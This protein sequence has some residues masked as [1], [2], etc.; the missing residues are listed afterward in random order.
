MD[1][2][3]TQID[4]LNTLIAELDLVL[5]KLNEASNKAFREMSDLVAQRELLTS[6]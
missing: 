3:Q 5:E 6:S 1:D 4:K 2:K